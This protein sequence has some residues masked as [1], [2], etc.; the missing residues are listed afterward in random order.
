MKQ[1]LLLILLFTL[2]SALS[3]KESA[4]P[5]RKKALAGDL[6]AMVT[7]GDE[8]FR[9]VNRPANPSLG[10]FW[11]RKAA[12][13]GNAPGKYRYGVCLEFGWGTK[14]SPRLAFEE[15]KGASTLPAARLRVAEMLLKGVPAGNEL[16][17]II[18][19]REKAVGI[20][21]DLCKE[22]FYPALEK[23]AKT[24]Y[25]F[26][27]TRKSHAKEIY[28]LVLKSTNV[29]KPAPRLLTFQAKLLQEGVGVKQDFFFARALLEIAARNND[30]E[31]QYLFA[32]ALES[33]RGCAVDEKKAFDYCALSAKSAFPAA[34]VRM[35]DY[36]L[37]GKFLP[38][39]PAE[40]FKLYQ[41]AADKQYPPALYKLGW[42]SENGIGTEKNLQRAFNFYERSASLGD[43]GGNYH[44][45]RCFRDGIGVAADPAGAFFFFRRSAALG[46]KEG[47]LA[48]A[49]C[50]RTGRGCT[51]DEALSSRLREEAAK[52]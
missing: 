29:E 52:L 19:D 35:G 27:K 4:D 11:Y 5:L 43:A 30:A 36:H 37:E 46:S 25:E 38:H 50:Y 8:F 34:M 26:P 45:G 18:P 40:A 49:E 14:K 6:N 1:N 31:A 23:L 41:K 3:A 10:T 12:V 20:M 2:F 22:N 47:M 24:L 7:L 42:C 21:E 9:G 48:L 32:S 17:E 15:Y 28:G 16:A 51:P 44:A 39:D 33:G 13:G